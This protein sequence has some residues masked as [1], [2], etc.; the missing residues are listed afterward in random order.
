MVVCGCGKL[1]VSG[2]LSVVVVLLGHGNTPAMV[3][4]L[5]NSKISPEPSPKGP[6]VAGHVEYT[7]HDTA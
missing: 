1:V 4:S 3:L 2:S 6:E 5:E 7:D